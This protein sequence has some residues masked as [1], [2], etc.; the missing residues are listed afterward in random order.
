MKNDENKIINIVK[1]KGKFLS[2]KLYV[3]LNNAHL[4]SYDF[5]IFSDLF[6][7]KDSEEN[8]FS[9][10]QCSTIDNEFL[11]EI[12]NVTRLAREKNIKIGFSFDLN[13][14]FTQ[15]EIRD[16]R[17]FII[18]FL[19]FLKSLGAICFYFEEAN[20]LPKEFIADY[21]S[22]INGV[23]SFGST[24]ETNELSLSEFDLYH[25]GFN[26]IKSSFLEQTIDLYIKRKRKRDLE[27]VNLLINYDLHYFPNYYRIFNKFNNKELL[28]ILSKEKY[29]KIVF[30]NI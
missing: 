20:V 15:K 7:A 18:T 25:Y 8:K 3:A 23:T 12:T 6:I 19:N 4:N 9:S 10:F 27:N 1:F 22:K 21:F 14:S 13:K 16:N 17:E 5:L 11:N 28:S 29:F 2:K 26:A 24:I 30:K